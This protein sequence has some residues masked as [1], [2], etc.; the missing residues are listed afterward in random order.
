MSKLVSKI[1][2]AVSEVDHSKAAILCCMLCVVCITVI[3]Y[4]AFP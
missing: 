3:A 4:K 2:T 1:V